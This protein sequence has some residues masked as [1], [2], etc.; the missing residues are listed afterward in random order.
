MVIRSA[1]NGIIE[2][3]YIPVR[4]GQVGYMY[5]RVSRRLFGNAGTGAFVLGPDVAKPVMGVWRYA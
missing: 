3:D 1:Q 2:H 5:D 4:V